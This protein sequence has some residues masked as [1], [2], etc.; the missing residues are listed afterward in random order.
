M[1]PLL[2]VARGVRGNDLFALS[3]FAWGV[4]AAV[5]GGRGELGPFLLN[6]GAGVLAI[7]AAMGVAGLLIQRISRGELD[8]GGTGATAHGRPARM[9]LPGSLGALVEKDLRVAWR[10]PALKA[11]LFLGL[12]GPLLFLVFMLQGGGARGGRG[13]LYLA[14][15]I[16]ASAFGSNAFGL[17]RR[18]VTLLLGFPV[19][20][21]RILVG[22][23]LGA[24]V[25]RLP[26]LLT[27]LGVGL[28]L[29]PPSF[30]PA[31]TTLAL[32]AMIIAAGVDNYVSIL[33]PAAVPAPGQNPYAGT[34]GS[35][36]LMAAVLSLAMLMAAFL[37]AA[38]FLLLAWLPLLLGRTALWWGSLPLA[39]AGA[40]SVYAMLVGGAARLLERRE[41]GM[42]ERIL[43]DA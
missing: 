4:R 7:A 20:R 16:G 8:L 23:N 22:K 42:L 15:F 41:T 19:P 24:L 2:A 29:A 14:M 1:R 21:W 5:Y 11:S 30:L 37:V 3:P 38:P 25:F 28:L 12:V 32:V 35:R 36:G 13:L 6:A 18:A 9:V 33:F 10:D 26:G 31:A 43:G 34:A 40:V 17:E 27:L 39:L